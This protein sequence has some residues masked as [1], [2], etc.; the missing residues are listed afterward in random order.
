MRVFDCNQDE[1]EELLDFEIDAGHKWTLPGV[2]CEVCG[3]TWATTGV[4]YPTVDISAEPYAKEYVN[5]W[6]VSLAELEQRR[7]RIR[8]HFQADALLPPG[9]DF[10]PLEGKASG[11]F[12]DFVWLSPWTLLL[13][14]VAYEQLRSHDV[15]LPRAVAPQLRFSGNQPVDLVELEIEP[16]ALLAA[17]SFLPNGEPCLGCG[18]D[19]R[20]VN[21]PVVSASSL[22]QDVD[23]FRPRNFPTYILGNERFREAVEALSLKGIVFSELKCY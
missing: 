1:S 15:A 3:D 20:R 12:P 19:A 14:R 13:K 4:E 6:P 10:G 18:R 7:A 8:S 9:A 5:G 23:L 11:R 16:L 22:P 17:E 21:V 2:K